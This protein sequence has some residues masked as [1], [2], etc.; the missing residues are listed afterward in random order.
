[1][2]IETKFDLGQVVFLIKHDRKPIR[3]PCDQCGGVVEYETP[4]G[5]KV[6]CPKCRYA[7]LHGHPRGTMGS[8]MVSQWYV[9][10]SGT[11]GRFSTTRHDYSGGDPDNTFVNY[12]PP[13]PGSDK[14]QYMFWETGVGSGILHDPDIMFATTEEAQEECDRRNKEA[15]NG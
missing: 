4:T 7:Y 5:V 2:I 10:G 1:M 14:E 13:E 11:I 15:D 6:E 8:F 9:F 12:K 3:V